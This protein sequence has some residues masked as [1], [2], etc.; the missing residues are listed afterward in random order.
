[1]LS[2]KGENPVNRIN[3][4]KW[5]DVLILRIIEWPE[6]GTKNPRTWS[7]VR[8]NGYENPY[9]STQHLFTTAQSPLAVVATA[10]TEVGFI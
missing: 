1:M 2:D 9:Q 8:E 7:G 5:G 3:V 10:M 4:I 6:V